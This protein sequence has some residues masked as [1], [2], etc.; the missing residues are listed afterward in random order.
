MER[1]EQEIKSLTSRLEIK[2]NMYISQIHIL[3]EEVTFTQ[4]KGQA[5]REKYE[6][7]ITEVKEEADA[8]KNQL[9]K[10]KSENEQLVV[11]NEETVSSLL[12]LA[13]ENEQLQDKVK[14]MEKK[15]AENT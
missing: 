6:E 11:K 8:V 13:S 4:S 1:Y 7:A 12:K 15:I 5:E 10:A 2:D 14:T 9:D 3:E